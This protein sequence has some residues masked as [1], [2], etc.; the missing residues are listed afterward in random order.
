MNKKI[1]RKPSIVSFLLA[2]VILG[3]G[4]SLDPYEL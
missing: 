4:N 1:R 2:E 3:Y